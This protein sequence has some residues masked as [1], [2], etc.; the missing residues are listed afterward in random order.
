MKVCGNGDIG[1]GGDLGSI[2]AFQIER[3]GYRVVQ[4]ALSIGGVGGFL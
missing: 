3:G 2:I 4:K 1:N